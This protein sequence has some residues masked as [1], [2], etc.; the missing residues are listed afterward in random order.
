MG[1]MGAPGLQG[2]RGDNGED[3]DTGPQGPQVSVPPSAAQLG[4]GEVAAVL[5]QNAV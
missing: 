3:G 2:P 4:I 1:E 5:Y